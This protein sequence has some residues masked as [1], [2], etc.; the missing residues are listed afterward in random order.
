MAEAATYGILRRY[1]IDTVEKPRKDINP[2]RKAS[3]SADHGKPTQQ[4][5]R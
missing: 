2:R 5:T 1:W 3:F 4:A